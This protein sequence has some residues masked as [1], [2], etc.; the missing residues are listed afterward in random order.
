MKKLLSLVFFTS[1]IC[2]AQGMIGLHLDYYPTLEKKGEASKCV[3]RENGYALKDSYY[4]RYGKY[5]RD[6][7]VIKIPE[8][9][10]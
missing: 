3:L 4:E 1:S 7:C 10:F 5:V 2:Q 9:E 8:V 6:Y